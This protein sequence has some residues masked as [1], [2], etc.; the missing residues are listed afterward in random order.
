[1]AES[2]AMYQQ[3]VFQPPRKKMGAGVIVAIVAGALAVI[4]V[5]CGVIGVIVWRLNTAGDL[6]ATPR[7]PEPKPG[8]CLTDVKF[9]P[10][11]AQLVKCDD[12]DAIYVIAEVITDTTY[13]E[14]S[15]ECAKLLTYAFLWKGK[16]PITASSR[17]TVIC[18][19]TKPPR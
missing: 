1:M 12:P 7:S 13:G 3:P 4:L 2:V 15:Q 18:V 19:R 14:G 11:S 17:G 9:H 5:A 6:S 10:E 8:D 16:A